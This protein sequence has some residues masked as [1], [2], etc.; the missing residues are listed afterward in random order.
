MEHIVTLACNTPDVISQSFLTQFASK[1]NPVWL[2]EGYAVDISMSGD[3]PDIQETVKHAISDAPIDWCVQ[4]PRHRRKQLLISD[5]DSTIIEQECIDELAA[6]IGIKEQ[7][8]LITE[9]AMRGELDFSDSLRARVALLEGLDT[10]MLQDVW[11]NHITISPD[12]ACVI[13]TMKAHGATTMLVSGGFTY[14]TQRV[15]DVLSFDTHHANILH[16]EGGKLTGTVQEPILDASAKERLLNDACKQH[17]VSLDDTLAVGDGA[18][19]VEMIRAAGL[20]VAYRAKPFLQT[21]ANAS[22]THTTLASLL[23]FQGYHYDA[24]IHPSL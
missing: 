9:R 6:R 19:D 15:A 23:Y 22:I 20:G 18:N 17:A 11:Q 21:H 5:M 4:L 7:I 24:F 1:G 14:F 16:E 10:V 8:A 3:M 2:C 13:A 12:A